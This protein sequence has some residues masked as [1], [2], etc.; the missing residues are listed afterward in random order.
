MRGNENKS[1]KTCDFIGY[2]CRLCVVLPQVGRHGLESAFWNLYKRDH[3]I[4]QQAANSSDYYFCTSYKFGL[5]IYIYTY[6]GFVSGQFHIYFYIHVLGLY[7]NFRVI[8]DFKIKHF[9]FPFFVY[10]YLADDTL[11]WFLSSKYGH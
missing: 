5:I 4:E 1:K 11:Y 8:I 9:V 7:V 3:F 6:S 2:Y 10:N